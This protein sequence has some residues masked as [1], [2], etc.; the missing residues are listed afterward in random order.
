MKF[1]VNRTHF[2]KTQLAIKI[3]LMKQ[4]GHQFATLCTHVENADIAPCSLKYGRDSFLRL[5]FLTRSRPTQPPIQWEPVVLT[6][7]VMRPKREADHSPPCS[8]EVKNEWACVHSHVGL[9]VVHMASFLILNQGTIWLRVAC[10]TPQSLCALD[11][12][13]G[14]SQS[15]SLSA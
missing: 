13:V 11:G 12:R 4:T 10:L 15:V 8:A 3:R 9:H 7:K 2:I 14:G 6:T 1:I 5:S